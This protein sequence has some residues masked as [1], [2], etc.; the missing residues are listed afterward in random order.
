MSELI[1]HKPTE[2]TDIHRTLHLTD[3]VLLAAHGT[4]EADHITGHKAILGKHRKTE[5]KREEDRRK[6]GRTE[7]SLS[8]ST[9]KKIILNNKRNFKLQKYL[10]MEQY[11]FE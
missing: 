5:G 9:E 1:C 10:E 8:S 11:T 2:W 7:N 4:P 3:R 6:Q